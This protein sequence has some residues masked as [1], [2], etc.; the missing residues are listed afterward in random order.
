MIRLTN[1][2]DYAV[3]LMCEIAQSNCRMNAQDLSAATG[4]PVPTVSKILNLLSRGSLLA[5]KRGIGGGFCLSN[6]PESISVA[7][8]VEAIDGPI[9][10]TSCAEKP[11]GDCSIDHICAMR[12]RWQVINGAV[13]TALDDVK[14]A[15]LISE[16]SNPMPALSPTSS[17]PS[18]TR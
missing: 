4:V 9:A 2:A 12:P 7:D 10:M 8:I 5:S 11:G 15:H 13:R 17:Q 3:V 14:L 18:A 1:L 16:R 6:T